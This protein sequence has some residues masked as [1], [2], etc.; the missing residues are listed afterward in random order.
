MSNPRVVVI[1]GFTASPSAHWF[2][3]LK[4]TLGAEGVEVDVVEL[5]SPSEP[6]P[7][8]WIA[9]ARG[10]IGTP[11]E[12]TVVVGHSIGCFTVVR[13]LD[14][15]PGDWRLGGLVLVGGFGAPLE[16]GNPL[17]VPFFDAQPDLGAL[18]R[19]TAHRTMIY[20]DSDEVIPAAASLE[21]AAALDAET[22][23]VPGAGHFTAAAGVTELPVAAEAIRAAL[24]D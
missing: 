1:H 20:S 19:R 5:P 4:Q 16:G 12:S 22:V 24:R 7:A 6:V 13:A 9:A 23:E 17:L 2:P 10:A 3:W 21:L 11:D 18:A 8:E 14:E 15:T